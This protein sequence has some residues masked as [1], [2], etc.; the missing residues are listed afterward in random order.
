MKRAILVSAA[1]LLALAACSKKTDTAATGTAAP[2]TATAAA[3]PAAP[4]TPPSRKAGLWEQ[5][6]STDKISQ[7]MKMCLDA[8]ADQKMKW[9]GSQAPGKSNCE[10]QSITPHLGGGW[11][12]H[13]VCAM[14]ESGTVTSDGSATGD[15]S[16]HYKVEVTS[17]T[18]GSPMAQANGTHKATIEATWTGPCPADMKPGDMEL[19]GGMKINMSGGSP[20]VT[21]GPG[22][23]DMAKLRAQAMSGHMDPAEMAKLKAQAAEMAKAAKSQQQ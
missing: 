21:T 18:S 23:M 3:T 12:F 1:A 15:F 11:D 8:A 17:V 19:P 6:I 5:K 14:G 10:Q 4:A 20:T 2:A 13:A 22:G 16:S 7:T 9:W